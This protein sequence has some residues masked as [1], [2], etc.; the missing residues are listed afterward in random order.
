MDKITPILHR[1]GFIALLA[2]LFVMDA[3]S[4]TCAEL[5][6]PVPDVNRK[7]DWAKELGIA[8]PKWDSLSSKPVDCPMVG[9][10]LLGTYIIQDAAT[11]EVRFEIS[12]ED[13]FDVRS[14]FFARKSNGHFKLTFPVGKAGGEAD[15]DLW[16]AQIK[17]KLNVG[18]GVLGVRVFAD[19]NS[20]VIVFELTHLKDPMT[21]QWDFVPDTQGYNQNKPPNDGYV[22]YP[23]PMVETIDDCQVSTQ[24]MPVDARYKTEKEP[25]PSQHATAW[26]IVKD[27]TH[28]RTYIFTSVGYSYQ[29]GPVARQEAV[30]NVNKAVAKGFAVVESEHQKWWHDFYRK[31]FVSMPEKYRNYHWLQTYKIASIV[32]ANNRHIPDLQGPWYDR[33]VSWNGIWWNWNLH[34]MFCSMFTSNHPELCNALLNYLWDRRMQMT[35]GG[36]YGIGRYSALYRRFN[37]GPE[38]GNLSSVLSILWENFQVTQDVDMLKSRL[39]PLIKG[40]YA[41]LM[42]KT[43][44][45]ANG[46]I[47][48][49]QGSSPEW[50]DLKKFNK[51]L[52]NDTAYDLSALRWVC[53]TLIQANDSYGLNDP[54]RAKWQE[55]MGKI[56]PYNTDP[57]E[58]F[59]IAKGIRLDEGYRHPSHE[60]MMWP[61]LEYTPDDP[62]QNELIEKTINH[63]D[64]L[65][66]SFYGMGNAANAI[67]RAMQG[68][69]DKALEGLDGNSQTYFKMAALSK[70]TGRLMYGNGGY[71]EEGPYLAHRVLE[72]ML[73]SSF[74]GIIRVFPAIPSSSDWDNLAI[75][76]FRAKGAFLVSAV[77]KDKQTRFIKI[78]SLAGKECKVK[79]GMNGN[80]NIASNYGC[81]L[82]DLGNGVV[83]INGLKEGQWCILHSG[84]SIP[85]LTI[86]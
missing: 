21:F 17:S 35:F 61:Y 62:A 44:R 7:I 12:R 81:S 52:F 4:V 83:R 2:T 42:S 50:N 25:K 51:A 55:T 5:G 64:S 40:N 31:S 37:D 34:T 82:T 71:C 75:D 29:R 1:A 6:A 78:T 30:D 77:R 45:D 8:S 32:R 49:P 43:T 76:N 46:L 47:H 57:K 58:G 54:D 60:Y 72:E 86:Q 20:N 13:L 84:N 59:M 79:T 28:S 33:N 68:K 27:P 39:F 38:H 63:H 53:R 36:G 41:Y 48:I 22:P 26:R 69:G 19:A 10:G 73:L 74:N 67:V 3:G 15:L 65:G 85:D 9:N 14:N 66:Y 23:A 24:D 11:G 70:K 56:T 16:N 18:G 80:V